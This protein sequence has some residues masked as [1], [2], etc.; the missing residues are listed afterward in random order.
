MDVS[1]PPPKTF[2]TH[3]QD[4]SPPSSWRLS[5]FRTFRLPVRRFAPYVR[6]FA[7]Y[8]RRFALYVR[9]FAPYWDVSPLRKTFRLLRKMFSPLSK[10]S[11]FEPLCETFRPHS[12]R[13]FRPHSYRTF[14]PYASRF[15]PR[16]HR[17]F[18]NLEKTFRPLSYRTF[19]TP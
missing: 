10:L 8:V 14:A 12:Y 17:T 13:T 15:A 9:R 7:P 18:Q 5:Q 1:P 6:R 19:R 11:H 16:S 4:V 2:R 3:L